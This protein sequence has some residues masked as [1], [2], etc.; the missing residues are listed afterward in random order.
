MNTVAERF[1]GS[2]RREVL[3][4][5]VVF[6]Q[7]QIK[8]ILGSYIRKYYNTKQPHQGTEQ[9]VPGGYETQREGKIVQSR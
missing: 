7:K 5:F 1:V 6:W 2:V 3:D 8:H 4:A 9:R